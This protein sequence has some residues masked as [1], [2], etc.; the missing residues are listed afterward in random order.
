MLPNQALQP[1]PFGHGWAWAL[2]HNM[3]HLLWLFSI[4]NIAIF[5][6]VNGMYCQLL[7]GIIFIG[8]IFCAYGS[9]IS[10]KNNNTTPSVVAT[11]SA[12]VFIVPLSCILAWVLFIALGSIGHI[13][14][15]VFPIQ[16]YVP[17]FSAYYIIPTYIGISYI[18]MSILFL[19][20]AW[21][22]RSKFQFHTILLVFYTII[23]LFYVAYIS[24]WHLTHQTYEYM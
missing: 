13:G 24:W 11:I 18:G 16:F 12:S 8:F 6:G 2:D 9:Y 5:S 17:Y 21:F 14:E 10:I 4:L 23:I 1:K 19:I 7:F 22:E 3:K 15:Q 20:A